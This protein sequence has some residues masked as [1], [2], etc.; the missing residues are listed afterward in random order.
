MRVAYI[1]LAPFIS[2]A[3]RALQLI[4]T[5]AP[6]HGLEPVVLCPP[7]S[8]FHEW[9]ETHGVPHEA[10]V[11][12]ERDKRHPIRWFTSVARVARALRRHRVELVH[13]NQVWAFAA[14]GTAARRLE[15][16]RVCHMRDEVGVEAVKW[17]C[18]SGVEGVVC[19]S[20]HIEAMMAPAWAESATPPILKTLHDP[21]VVP[22][23]PAPDHRDARAEARK[24]Y[25]VES[26]AV[27]LGF[28][29]QIAPIKGVKELLAACEPLTSRPDWT[30]LIAG[31]DP[32]PGRPYENECRQWVSDRGLG[33]RVRFVGFLD[34]VREFYRAIDVAVVP[35]LK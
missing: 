22:S 5:Q 16:P 25:H 14:A 17:W 13:S 24:R 10:V 32:Q 2:G 31:R 11:L 18:R 4:V 3:E 19:I 8:P 9:C 29:G 7:G 33:D 23:S 34:D 26:N 27:V 30:L 20:A 1:T 28:I 35:S 12:A 21:V 6:T 15:I